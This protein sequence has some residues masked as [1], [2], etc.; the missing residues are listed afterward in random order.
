MIFLIIFGVMVLV[1]TIWAISVIFD[2]DT[3]DSWG[4]IVII[5]LLVCLIITISL[6]TST[7]SFE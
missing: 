4:Y 2:W 3:R 6:T 1:T 5:T 7:S